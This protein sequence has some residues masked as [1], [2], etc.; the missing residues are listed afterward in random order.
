MGSGRPLSCLARN[1]V[2][3]ANQRIIA[4]VFQGPVF[5]QLDCDCQVFVCSSKM[6][7]KRTRLLVFLSEEEGEE[8]DKEKAPVMIAREA[9]LSVFVFF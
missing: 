2:S 6:I 1:S 4:F 8:E 3:N 7:W 5:A 9:V